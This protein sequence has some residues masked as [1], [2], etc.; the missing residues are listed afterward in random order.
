MTNESPTRRKWFQFKLMTLLVAVLVL[1]LPLSWVAVRMRRV[2][3]QRVVTEQLESIGWSV[4]FH[5]MR[6]VSPLNRNQAYSFE[7]PYSLKVIPVDFVH[8][9]SSDVR[10][11]DLRLVAEL[12][13]LALSL[14][15]TEVTDRGLAH[16][17][18][19][20]NLR[21][22]WLDDTRV[23]DAGLEY[24]KGLPDIHILGVANTSVTPEGVNKLQKAL[25]NCKIEY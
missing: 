18:R 14:S 15:D 7:P 22:L 4:E 21:Y 12:A 16:L 10:D 2:R 5:D 24:L 25:P 8:A 23:T 9:A 13:P 1:S 3:R 17:S 6:I 19:L 20:T 11:G